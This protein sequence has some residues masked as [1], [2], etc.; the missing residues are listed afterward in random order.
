MIVE[1]ASTFCPTPQYFTFYSWFCFHCRRGGSHGALIKIHCQAI[2]LTCKYRTITLS[3]NLSLTGLIKRSTSF[4]DKTMIYVPML[5]RTG[6]MC[7][8][9][10]FDLQ[11]LCYRKWNIV[12]VSHITTQVEKQK[13]ID[14]ALH[15]NVKCCSKYRYRSFDSPSIQ[16]QPT[17]QS[18]YVAINI[19]QSRT[20]LRF[21][22]TGNG[23][24]SNPNFLYFSEVNQIWKYVTQH[25]VMASVN[26]IDYSIYWIYLAIYTKWTNVFCNLPASNSCRP[27]T[28][29]P[30]SQ[31]SRCYQCTFGSDKPQHK[32]RYYKPTCAQ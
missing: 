27:K 21:W 4:L 1:N 10:P 15:Q 18:Q 8:K 2:L 26:L 12:K 5:N 22:S 3:K 28:W 9:L 29:C 32:L 6:S 25:H 20:M 24:W 7:I 23:C 14:H 17:E 11:L 19:N 13:Q 16:A 31:F 30:Q